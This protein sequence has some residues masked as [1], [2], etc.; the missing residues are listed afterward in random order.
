MH[1]AAYLRKEIMK[2]HI[3]RMVWLAALL[4]AMNASAHHNSTAAFTT[5]II[6]VEGYVTDFS[7]TN[8]HVN[9]LFDVTDENGETTQWL[10]E[11]S[12]ATS[13][14]RA[15]WTANTLEAGQFLRIT[16][17]ETRDGSPMILIRDIVELDPADGSLVRN[18]QGDSDY[19]EPLGNVSLALTLDDGRP[20]LSGAWI[21]G[22]RLVAFNDLRPPFNETGAAMQAQYDPVSDPASSCQLPGLVRQ[23]AFTPHPVRVTQKDDHV[24]LEYEEYAGRRVVYLDDQREPPTNQHANFG[25]SVAYYEGDALVIETTQLLGNYSN[26]L[27]LALS[28]QATIVET[29]RRMDDPDMGPGLAME[30]VITDPG[31]LT[32][33]WTVNWLKYYSESYEFIEVDCRVTFTYREPD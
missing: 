8:P 27:G 21:R 10:A 18:V 14:R 23:A 15:G 11:S 4:G 17:R 24:I 13:L 6:D 7:F 31:H 3:L 16:G 12:A 29:Y 32:A 25:H 2:I 20:N 33:P 1:G 9:F 5:N 22:P 28:D 26:P 30:V 19:E